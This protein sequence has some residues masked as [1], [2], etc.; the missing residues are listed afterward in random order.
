MLE[1]MDLIVITGP[2]FGVDSTVI[3]ASP[4]RVPVAFY[5]VIFDPFRREAIGFVYPNSP[6]VSSAISDYQVPIEQIE[7][8]TGMTFISTRQ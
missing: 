4:V 8:V 1:R 7:R 6:P 2:V 5:K 3:G